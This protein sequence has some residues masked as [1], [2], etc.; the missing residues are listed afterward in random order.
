MT[1]LQKL[2][3]AIF[4]FSFA[5]GV[6]GTVWSI[7]SSFAALAVVENAGIGSVGGFLSNAIYFSAGAFFG[8]IAGG[9]LIIVGRSKQGSN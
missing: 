4:L 7:Y 8:M 5:I 9:V 3:I 2:G 6:I 1:S